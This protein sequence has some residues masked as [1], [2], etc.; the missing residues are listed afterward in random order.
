GT[1]V[2]P[3][4]AIAEGAAAAGSVLDSVGAATGGR[5]QLEPAVPLVLRLGPGPGGVGRDHVYTQPRALR[6]ARVG[7]EVFR[8]GGGQRAGRRVRL[9][10]SFH[11]GRN[12][13]PV[14][15][16]A[17]EFSAQGPAGGQAAGGRRQQS[18][19]GPPRGEAHERNAPVHDRS[20]G[21]AGEKES[22]KRCATGA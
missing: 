20:R 13:D 21:P 5:R 16:L 19:G 15:G 8:A 9:E 17:E 18:V 7:A 1:S 6:A 11:R 22:W 3:A 10:R 14:L 4:G 2:D 12:A